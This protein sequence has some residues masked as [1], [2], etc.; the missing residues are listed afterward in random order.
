[1]TLLHHIDWLIHRNKTTCIYH[2]IKWGQ[3]TVIQSMS[4]KSMLGLTSDGP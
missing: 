1:M 2:L 3:V 4:Y